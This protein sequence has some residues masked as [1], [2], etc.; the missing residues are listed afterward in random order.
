MT[1]LLYYMMTLLHWGFCLK[2]GSMCR[3][4][5]SQATKRTRDKAW[6]SRV[7]DTEILLEFALNH[8]PLESHPESLSA[9]EWERDFG[10]CS[11]LPP[12]RPVF[13][14]DGGLEAM[15][16]YDFLH[17]HL[18]LSI[19]PANTHRVYFTWL[20]TIL[21]VSLESMLKCILQTRL[22]AFRVV[23]L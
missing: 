2:V 5:V 14:L 22:G 11:V 3:I 9:S 21:C 15:G 4:P 20:W 10:F 12:R 8:S 6:V 18:V 7:I 13:P 23:W 19:P 16:D 17:I 1:S